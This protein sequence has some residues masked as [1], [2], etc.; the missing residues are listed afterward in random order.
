MLIPRKIWL[1]WSQGV[2]E[3]PFIVKKCIDSWV[4]ENPTWDVVVLDENNLNKYISLNLPKNV[5]ANLCIAHQSDLIRLALLSKYG[6]IWT[7]ATTFCTKPL[8]E[9]IDDAC[10]EAGF[11]VFHSQMLR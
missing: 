1:F 4:K 8:D 3:A 11:F 6:G 5:I 10:S 9:W 7:D 2:S